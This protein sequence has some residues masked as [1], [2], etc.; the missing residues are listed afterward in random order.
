MQ[1]FLDSGNVDEVRELNANYLISGVTTNPTLIA[2]NGKTMRET[3]S[4]ISAVFGGVLNA[5]VYAENYDDMMAQVREFLSWNPALTIKLPAS[6]LGLRL[7]RELTNQHI[8]TNVTLVMNLGQALLASEA[9]ATYVSPFVGRLDDAN[10]DGVGFVRSIRKSFNQAGSRTKILAASIR[11][12]DKLYAV[13]EAGADIVTAPFSVYQEFFDDPQFVAGM[14]KFREDS[15]K[16][17]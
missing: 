6:P 4:E 9:G 1:F 17:S 7:T 16:F 2:K 15:K 8:P 13:A 5:E 11:S 14:D 10:R 12:L 3:L